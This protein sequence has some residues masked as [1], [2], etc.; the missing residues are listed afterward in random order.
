[1]TPQGKLTIFLYIV[2]VIGGIILGRN[3]PRR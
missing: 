2:G 3:I 1:M